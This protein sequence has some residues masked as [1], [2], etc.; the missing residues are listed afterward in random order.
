MKRDKGL[1]TLLDLDGSIFVQE[2]KSWIKIETKRLK[3][4][5]NER[6]HGIKYSLTLHSPDGARILGFDNAHAVK[7]KSRKKYFGQI[8]T[9]D[10]QHHS[11]DESI[12]SY[13]FSSPEQLLEDFFHEV[14]EYLKKK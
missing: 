4:P 9:Y 6:P 1:D 5:S 10:H 7:V 2:D 14:D 12:T 8:I 11:T 3:A 13:S